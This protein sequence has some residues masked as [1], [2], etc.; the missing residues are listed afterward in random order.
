MILY[1][2]FVFVLIFISVSISKLIIQ[3]R[4]YISKIS[5]ILTYTLTP[6]CLVSVLLLTG[7]LDHILLAIEYI[8]FN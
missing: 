6:V 4:S 7:L 1:L 8:D 5:I 2:L 3:K